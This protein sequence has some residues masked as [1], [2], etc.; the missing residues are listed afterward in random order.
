MGDLGGLGKGMFCFRGFEERSPSW[1]TP[2]RCEAN[3]GVRKICFHISSFYA[4]LRRFFPR[5]SVLSSLKPKKRNFFTF[6]LF[7]GIRCI[8]L[9]YDIQCTDG[10]TP[11]SRPQ[12]Y[13]S[14]A[15]VTH[16][17]MRWKRPQTPGLN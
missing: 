16:N 6:S 4:F 2:Q 10:R 8:C 14:H 1:T 13:T 3:A 11:S 7:V 15:N 12:L 9:G 17:T 5:N